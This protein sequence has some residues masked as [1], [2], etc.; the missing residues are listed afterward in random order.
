MFYSSSKNIVSKTC[1]SAAKQ[2]IETNPNILAS[3]TQ[4][5][6]PKRILLDKCIE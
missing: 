6:L 5:V 4:I 2:F 3:C 1:S